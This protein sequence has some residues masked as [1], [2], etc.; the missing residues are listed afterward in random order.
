MLMR[1]GSTMMGGAAATM[2][3]MALLA[4]IG[5]FLAGLGVGAALVGGA[6]LARQA[7]NR[8][9][10]WR[11]DGAGMGM[12]NDPLPPMPDEGEAPS[13]AAPV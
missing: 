6:C 11:E 3:G 4:G 12:A 7:M 5:P 10:G 1:C 9:S 2:G 8:R 13:G